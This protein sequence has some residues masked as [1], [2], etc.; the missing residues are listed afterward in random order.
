[1]IWVLQAWIMPGLR[2]FLLRG[3]YF[4]YQLDARK[5]YFVKIFKKEV[6]MTYLYV[7]YADNC[8]KEGF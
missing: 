7:I 2:H 1:L 6:L 5:L 3:R 4:C 8:I